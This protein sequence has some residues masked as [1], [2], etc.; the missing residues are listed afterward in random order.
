MATRC[1]GREVVVVHGDLLDGDHRGHLPAKSTSSIRAHSIHPL[2]KADS[3][4]VTRDADCRTGEAYRPASGRRSR[5]H[6]TRPHSSPPDART[7]ATGC[8]APGGH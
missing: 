4:V 7:H 8:S 6:V 2:E 3:E 5:P 1:T